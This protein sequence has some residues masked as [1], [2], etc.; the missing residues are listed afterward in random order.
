MENTYLLKD[1]SENQLDFTND[2][3]DRKTDDFRDKTSN[4]YLL[5]NHAPSV[6]IDNVR[7]HRK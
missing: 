4:D 5:D 2:A 7:C 1:Y 3:T 6:M